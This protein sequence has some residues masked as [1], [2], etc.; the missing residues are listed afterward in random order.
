MQFIERMQHYVFPITNVNP[1]GTIQ[2][3]LN[4]RLDADAP[5]RLTGIAI[6]TNNTAG[7]FFDGQ[8]ALRFM[9][10]DGRLNQKLFFPANTLA[11]GNSYAG[12]PSP[13]TANPNQALISPVRP[14]IIY[15][16]ES[17]ITMDVQTL[18]P[19]V[20]NPSAI[21]IFCGTKLYKQGSIW[22]PTYPKKFT[23]R[24]YL[25]SLLVPN[26]TI[27]SGPVLN[28]PFLV[29]RDAD[30]VFQMGMYSDVNAASGGVPNSLVDLGIRMKDAF[31]QA[32]TNVYIPAPL[33]FP[34]MTA[35]QPG[36]AYPEVYIPKDQLLLFDFKY[37]WS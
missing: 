13:S 2:E 15:P 18:N 28:Q 3:G 29:E 30:F 20:N 23:A 25:N 8:M 5:F 21:V 16:P 10:P 32:Y 4:L 1:A 22:A 35:Q 6:W 37:L 36:F 11:P 9:R 19:A 34:F 7:G 14:N 31:G 27:S 26:V 33:L 12:S 24:P 17:V